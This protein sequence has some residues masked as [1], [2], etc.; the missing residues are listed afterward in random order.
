M[1]IK[2]TLNTL[3]DENGRTYFT[4]EYDENILKDLSIAL[5]ADPELKNMTLMTAAYIVS[6]ENSPETILEK[7]RSFAEDIKEQKIN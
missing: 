5:L 6:Q 1:E 7:I 3:T 4:T 2:L